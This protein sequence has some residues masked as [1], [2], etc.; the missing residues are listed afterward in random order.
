MR[1]LGGVS[2]ASFAKHLVTINEVTFAKLLNHLYGEAVNDKLFDRVAFSSKNMKRQKSDL[3]RQFAEEF[4]RTSGGKA[5][6]MG[7]D[8]LSPIEWL[9]ALTDWH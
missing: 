9:K 1:K 6:E 3:F 4:V 8:N 2:D 5:A 7:F